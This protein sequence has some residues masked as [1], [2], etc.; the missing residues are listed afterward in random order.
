MYPNFPVELNFFFKTAVME[1]EKTICCCC[2]LVSFDDNIS[3]KAQ[4]MRTIY[5]SAYAQFIQFIQVAFITFRFEIIL[6]NIWKVHRKFSGCYSF[7]RNQYLF[8]INNT[9]LTENIW[10]ILYSWI[11]TKIA[12]RL[13]IWRWMDSSFKANTGHFRL[14][15]HFSEWIIDVNINI[16]GDGGKLITNNG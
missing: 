14:T 11:F 8:S 7:I 10:Q 12:R 5:R 15:Q 13:N 6:S 16:V 1:V 9:V 4:S 2:V 3:F